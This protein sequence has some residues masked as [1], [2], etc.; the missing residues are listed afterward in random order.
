[1]NALA[2]ID[3]EKLRKIM[4][5]IGHR[6]G[7]QADIASGMKSRLPGDILPEQNIHNI[8]LA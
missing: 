2:G 1:M 8:T 5:M 3:P 7:A 4:A 6:T